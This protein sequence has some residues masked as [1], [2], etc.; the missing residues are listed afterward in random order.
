MLDFTVLSFSCP[1]PYF[2]NSF[3]S[4]CFVI[5]SYNLHFSPLIFSSTVPNTVFSKS[6][7]FIILFAFSVWEFILVPLQICCHILEYVFSANTL[8]LLFCFFENDKIVLKSSVWS[9]YGPIC[10]FQ[11]FQYF[12][13]TF[14]YLC[15]PGFLILYHTLHFLKICMK[16]IGI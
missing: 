8:Y 3:I 9:L 5:V 1:F 2:S 7:K 11:C 14:S 10:Y 6:T 16:L 12:S 15:V 4:P 13:F